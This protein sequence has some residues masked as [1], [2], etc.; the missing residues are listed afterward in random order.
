MGIAFGVSSTAVFVIIPFFGS[1]QVVDGQSAQDFRSPHTHVCSSNAIHK[2]GHN[3][4]LH[5]RSITIFRKCNGIVR[6]RQIANFKRTVASGGGSLCRADA[7]CHPFQR[8]TSLSCIGH[9]S[10]DFC[11]CILHLRADFGYLFFVE[12]SCHNGNAYRLVIGFRK[13]NYMCTY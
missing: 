10:F 9:F 5:D 13:C 12:F 8:S 1:F 11:S 6:Q 2:V 3:H 7:D 4:F